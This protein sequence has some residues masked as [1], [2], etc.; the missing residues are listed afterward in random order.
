MEEFTS[1]LAALL[2]GHRQFYPIS[3]K[4]FVKGWAAQQVEL[5]GNLFNCCRNVPYR[6]FGT[7]GS[8]QID[9]YSNRLFS[10]LTQLLIDQPPEV[11]EFTDQLQI[12]SPLPILDER[13]AEKVI[14]IVGNGH[15][16]KPRPI[17][18][19]QLF[20]AQFAGALMAEV[21]YKDRHHEL[22]NLAFNGPMSYFVY[23]RMASYTAEKAVLLSKPQLESAASENLKSLTSEVENYRAEF[24]ALKASQRNQLDIISGS[25]G[26]LA[27]KSEEIERNLDETQNKIRNFESTIREELRLDIARKSW[28]S[29][30][31]EARLAFKISVSL[32][33]LSLLSTIFIAVYW[34]LPITRALAGLD[35]DSPVSDQSLAIAMTHQLG[36]LLVLT[37]P[38]AVAL[39]MLRALMRYFMRSMLLMDDARQRQTMLDTYFLLTEQGRA[40]ERDRPLI[41]WALFRQT[42][43]HGPDGIEPPDFTEVIKAGLDRVK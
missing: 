28:E 36:R 3:E 1:S 6:E 4:I 2:S 17:A 13:E 41:L 31:Y 26:E 42:P 27:S 37:V 7:V 35:G 18:I 21:G 34:G 30:Y 24:D 20:A 15:V 23:G 16:D 32:L 8:V 39:W 9:E 12:V 5:Y 29:R 19:A 40:D 43:G 38:I 33:A 11:K 22:L 25:A 14:A 10:W